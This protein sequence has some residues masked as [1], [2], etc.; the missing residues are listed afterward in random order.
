MGAAEEARARVAAKMAEADAKYSERVRGPGGFGPRARD[1]AGTALC[2]RCHA[3][4]RVWSMSRFN[5][6][7]CCHAC[8]ERE[9]AHPLYAKAEAAEARAIRH[10]DYNFPG[11]GKPE[12]L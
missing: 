7:C 5:T 8:L 3:P 2:D 12:G 1:A 6:E 11:I 10:G 4:T 9:R